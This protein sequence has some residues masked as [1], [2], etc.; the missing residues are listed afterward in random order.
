MRDGQA[1]VNGS[2]QGTEHLVAGGGSG[3]AGVQV[4]GE[5]ARLAVDALH[6]ELVAR[7]LHLALVHLVQAKL[8]QEL[9]RQSD[10]TSEGKS[11]QNCKKTHQLSLDVLCGRAADQCSRLLR[12]WSSPQ[13]CHTWAARVSRQHTRSCHP[14]SWHRRSATQQQGKRKSITRSK[15]SSGGKYLTR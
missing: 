4:A 3:E 7:Y 10:I 14:R 15:N 1:A 11:R 2:L 12:S 9:Q 8:V 13:R 5:S 6:V